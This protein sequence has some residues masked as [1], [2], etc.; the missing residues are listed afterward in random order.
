[1]KNL[2]SDLTQFQ[3]VVASRY[4]DRVFRDMVKTLNRKNTTTNSS[5]ITLKQQP[6]NELQSNNR[7]ISS[8]VLELMQTLDVEEQEVLRSSF[9]LSNPQEC[10]FIRKAIKAVLSRKFV[11]VSVLS[12]RS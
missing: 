11:E 3:D 7:T 12:E 1:M 6:Q 4:L 9:P 2:T 5:P 10:R 8:N